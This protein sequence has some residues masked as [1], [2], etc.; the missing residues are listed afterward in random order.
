M[1]K[2]ANRYLA[3]EARRRRRERDSH[4]RWLVI[5]L[6]REVYGAAF[7]AGRMDASL[8][9]AMVPTFADEVPS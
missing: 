7:R 4:L 2:Q 9:R 6:L 5:A 1:K 8:V 3:D